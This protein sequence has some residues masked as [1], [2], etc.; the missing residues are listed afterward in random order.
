MT[1]KCRVQGAG[2]KGAGASPAPQHPCTLG[3]GGSM[4]M[5]GSQLYLA[6]ISSSHNRPK[7]KPKSNLHPN[8]NPNP[9]P[10]PNLNPNPNP[11][12]NYDRVPYCASS[13]HPA[14]KVPIVRAS[15]PTPAN[16]AQQ[17]GPGQSNPNPTDLTAPSHPRARTMAPLMA[18][19]SAGA[20]A[21]PA[22]GGFLGART[23][24]L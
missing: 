11:N 23:L 12:R 14:A 1:R 24:T 5:S 20:V 15:S 19:F 6:D 9:N 16:Q 17:T 18:S 8:P 10:K 7:P 21:G 13:C 3:V 2:C 22:L 4:Q